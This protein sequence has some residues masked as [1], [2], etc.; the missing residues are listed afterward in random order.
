MDDEISV[1][2]CGQKID[3][4]ISRRSNCALVKIWTALRAATLLV[5][6]EMEQRIE[7]KDDGQSDAA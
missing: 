7:R 5:E 3:L 4:T 2:A 6:E 1:T